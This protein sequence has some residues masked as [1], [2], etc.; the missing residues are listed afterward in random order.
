MR[1][2]RLAVSALLIGMMA[3]LSGCGGDEGAAGTYEH[4]EEGTIVLEDDGTGSWTQ[5]GDPAEFT[6]AQEGTSIT[7]TTEGGSTAEVDLVDGDLVIPP[8]FISGDEPVT[9]NRS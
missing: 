1:W 6:W 2:N 9:F 4:P 3:G 7:L 5:S 8:E